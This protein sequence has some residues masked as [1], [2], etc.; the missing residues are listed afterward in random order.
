MEPTEPVITIRLELADP[1]NIQD[2][3]SHFSGIGSEFE[4]YINEKRPDLRGEASM[5]VREVRKGSIVADIVAGGGALIEM[6][7][8]VLIMGGFA[9]LFSRRV[10]RFVAGGFLPEATK[11]Q[12]KNIYDSI[13]AV[14]E[15]RDG[16]LELTEAKYEGGQL[17]RETHLRLTSAEAR[18]AQVTIENQKRELD[19]E[20]HSDYIRVLMT[21]ERPSN[22]HKSV[23]ASTGERVIIEE[24]SERPKSLVYGSDLA[25]ERIKDEII[26]SDDNIF[27]LGFICD[28]NVK[29]KGGRIVAYSVTHVHQVIDIAED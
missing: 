18:Q 29:L 17:V 15:D 1:V 9:S 2:F 25:E 4:A 27:K 8:T 12:L 20:T 7:D 16:V 5:F 26:N 21:F 28:V 10:R 24:V 3:A 6:M 13:K 19:A 11:G 23:G 14:A 22:T